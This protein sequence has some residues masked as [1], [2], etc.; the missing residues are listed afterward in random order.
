MARQETRS[1]PRGNQHA[2][3]AEGGKGRKRRLVDCLRRSRRF[4][5]D[6]RS[7]PR[8]DHLSRPVCPCRAGIAWAR[9]TPV[10]TLTCQQSPSRGLRNAW[11]A[12]LMQVSDPRREEDLRLQ[13]DF[14]PPPAEF[15][16]MFRIGIDTPSQ[17]RGARAVG[18]ILGHW[19]E[20]ERRAA[21][22]QASNDDGGNLNP[23]QLQGH[24]RWAC[25]YRH[26][27]AIKKSPYRRRPHTILSKIA[28]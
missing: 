16:A 23:P 9:S 20:Q 21:P 26:K 25:R 13:L 19:S 6:E 18:R 27:A 4:D 22:R 24:H 3:E 2:I 28:F 15:S 12:N 17:M 10:I 1:D 5:V 14:S 8:F 7:L 11:L